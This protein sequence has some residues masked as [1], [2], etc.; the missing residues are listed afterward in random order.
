MKIITEIEQQFYG[1][2]VKKNDWLLLV[3]H[4]HYNRSIVASLSLPG[5]LDSGKILRAEIMPVIQDLRHLVNLLC[6]RW[7]EALILLIL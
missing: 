1:K 2:A 7:L 5:S 4:K 6:A 3:L